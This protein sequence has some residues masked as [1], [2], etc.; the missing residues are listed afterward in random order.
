MDV[1]LSHSAA[2]VTAD[3]LAP[4]FAG[5]P[6]P[7][8]PE[9][10]VEIVRAADVVVVA[11]DRA[12]ALAGFVTAITDGTFAA[13]I[14]LLE[15]HRDHQRT[16]IGTALM[17]SI[18]ERLEG[19]YMID[20]TC[21]AEVVPFYERLGGTSLAAIAW[22]D[23]SSVDPAIAAQVPLVRGYRDADEPAWLRCRLLSF[24][25]TDYYDDVVVRRP[26]FALPAI[27]LVAETHG[28]LVGLI[29][30]EVDGAAATID[31]IAVDPDRQR[32]G[33]AS[34]LLAAA[35]ARLPAEVTTL[36][37]WTRE[38]A[39]ANTWYRAHGFVENFRYLH[40][41]KEWDDPDDGWTSPA[42]LS[43]PVRAF[44]HA[45]IERES[46]LRARHRRVYVCRQYLRP[47]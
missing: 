24:F 25:G 1:T 46:E 8:T 21:D 9:R 6:Q 40:V 14:T 13:S 15:V 23:R 37:A 18:L 22:R 5:W 2:S 7:P 16:G 11:R 42:S 35:L 36:D 12:G 33:V 44:A 4:F 10:R 29:D 38:S 34:A 41:Y 43:A 20:L 27:R 28:A 47:L 31:C 39:A 19:C 30:V 45:A 32:S 17:T 3:D 26:E